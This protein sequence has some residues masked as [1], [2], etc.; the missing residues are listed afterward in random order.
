MKKQGR[1]KGNRYESDGFSQGTTKAFNLSVEVNSL[2]TDFALD[3][4]SEVYTDKRGL[5]EV[6][7]I[8]PKSHGLPRFRL[9]WHEKDNHLNV[10]MF[11]SH[12][13][14][15][16]EVNG[17]R[18]HTPSH[19]NGHTGRAF[20]VVITT[21]NQTVVDCVISFNLAEDVAIREKVGIHST[22]SFVLQKHEE[23][24]LSH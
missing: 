11:P 18:G 7:N 4:L 15:K 6:G 1:W 13:D 10:D 22:M 16:Q 8:V 19:A 20:A 2:N 17:Y 9:R 21:P 3:C 5:L 24:P 12:S 23:K 14:W